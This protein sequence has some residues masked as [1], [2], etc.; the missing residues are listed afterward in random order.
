M[1]EPKRFWNYIGE[2][3]RESRLPGIMYFN[4]IKLDDPKKIVNAVLSQFIAVAV[5]EGIQV[6]VVYLL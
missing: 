4:D 1:T 5:S 6:N 3:K 2:L